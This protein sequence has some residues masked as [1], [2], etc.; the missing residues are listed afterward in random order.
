MSLNAHFSWKLPVRLLSKECSGTVPA[1]SS[2]EWDKAPACK[3]APKEYKAVCGIVDKKPWGYEDGHS[4][5][6]R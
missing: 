3:K 2:P 4:C 1:S 5:P 6:L